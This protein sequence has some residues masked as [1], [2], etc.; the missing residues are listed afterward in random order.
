MFQSLNVIVYTQR[1]LNVARFVDSCIVALF[2]VVAYTQRFLN[3]Y[4]T[5]RERERERERWKPETL[6]WKIPPAANDSFAWG[7]S[8]ELF[9]G[10]TYLVEH[11]QAALTLGGTQ[12]GH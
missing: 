11:V 7:T 3:I 2:D 6:S 9:T 12:V 8:A 1:F 4:V 5:E 10:Y